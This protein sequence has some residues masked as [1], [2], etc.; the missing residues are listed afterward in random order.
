ML[1]LEPIPIISRAVSSS[2]NVSVDWKGPDPYDAIGD[3]NEQYLDDFKEINSVAD[4]AYIICCSEWLYYF[5]YDH[6][7]PEEATNFEQYI[8]GSWVWVCDL[9][10]KLA[11]YYNLTAVDE[12]RGRSANIDAVELA[13]DSVWEGVLSIPR[14]ET[15]VDATVVTQLCEYILPRDCGFKQWREVIL[16]RL[17]EKFPSG[18]K[19]PSLIQIS[20]RIFDTDVSLDDIVHEADCASLLGDMDFE[21][22]PYLPLT[23][24]DP[25]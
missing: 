9:P 4:L 25:D 19:N 1:K 3:L 18:E 23:E 5:L 11:P 8:I 10:R 6:F 7:E 2:P 15:N 22:N 17:K 20:R 24:P 21:G 12:S 14:E 16:Q 13:F